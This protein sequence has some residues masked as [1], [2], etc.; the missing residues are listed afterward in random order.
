MSGAALLDTSRGRWLLAIAALGEVRAIARGLSVEIDE[1][2]WSCTAIGDRFDAV[3]TGVGKANA[4]GAVARVLDPSRHAGVL[5]IGI[6]GTLPDGAGGWR[7]EIGEVVCASAS[8]FADE[9][10][11]T[12]TG[13]EDV[14]SMGFP[15]IGDGVSIA[16]DGAAIDRVRTVVDNVGPV[17]T[18]STCSGT[19]G[20][21]AD[22]ASRTGALC[23]GMEGAA[24][25]LAA[26]RV[27]GDA[28]PFLELRV[29]SNTTGDRASQRWEIARAF[30]RLGAL[31]RVL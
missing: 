1:S 20:L 15:P 6:A 23:E 26:K 7:C 5:S 21:A 22:I 4:A 9:G 30:D 8:V 11:R 13:F 18:V 17:A 2:P 31:A 29:I 14:A 28:F 16:C 12:P 10:V 19:D 27:A 24:A 3:V 25:G